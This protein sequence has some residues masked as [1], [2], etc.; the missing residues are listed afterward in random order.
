[1]LRL[2]SLERDGALPPRHLA[3]SHSGDWVYC[4]ATRTA[5]GLDIETTEDRAPRDWQALAQAAGA[6]AER[7]ELAA[8]AEPSAQGRRFLTLWTLKEAWFKQ[9]GQ[10]LDWALLPR[11]RTHPASGETAQA[12]VWQDMDNTLALVTDADAAHLPVRWLEG[13]SS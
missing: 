8:L 2:A 11:L 5:I 4:A 7:T 9:Q 3:L 13:P 6:P 12:R 10:G 1:P